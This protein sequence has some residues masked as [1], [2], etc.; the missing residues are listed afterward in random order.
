M[1]KLSTD[2]MIRRFQKALKVA[3]DTFDVSDIQERVRTGQ[4]QTFQHGDG[5][6]V[7]EILKLPK[8]R[9]MNVV[10]AA[11]DL[12]DVMV[13]HDEMV[14]FAKQHSCAKIIMRGR[15]GWRRVLKDHGWQEPTIA[16]ELS[17]GDDK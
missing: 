12:D 7:T 14:A 11:G 8:C 2:E 17:L 5:V 6:I 4:C 16:M 13:A 10:M 3:G 15:K 1:A 9:L